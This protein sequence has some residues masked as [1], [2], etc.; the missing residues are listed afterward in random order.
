MNN[1]VVVFQSAPNAIPDWMNLCMSTV[2]S[3]SGAQGIDYVQ[4]GDEEFLSAA[5]PWIGENSKDWIHPVTDIARLICAQKL[6]HR[7][8]FAIWIDADVIIF[9]PKNFEV[10]KPKEVAF[11][12]EFWIE[13]T[14]EGSLRC[15][16]NVSNYV[17]VFR[18][19]GDFISDYLKQAIALLQNSPGP[20]KQG[21]VGTSFLSRIVNP[22]KYEL[23]ERVANFS[24]LLIRALLTNEELTLN[25]F[26]NNAGR[27]FVAA[28]LCL[29]REDLVFQGILNSKSD[30]EKIASALIDYQGDRNQ[31]FDLLDF[32]GSAF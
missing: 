21:I 28:N 3:W 17:C 18:N 29:S 13:S 9:D 24:P 27:S 26:A 6:L 7:Y 16:N 14:L 12:R 8:D 5:P 32:A 22:E 15:L 19:Q 23:I 1:R 2:Q 31:E 11:V 25:Y 30:Y 4:V 20:Y 10:P